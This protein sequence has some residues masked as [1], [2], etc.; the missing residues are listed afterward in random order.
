MTTDTIPQAAQAEERNRKPLTRHLPT[1]GRVL[2]GLV[3]L[4]T[5]LN[6]F[7]NFLPPPKTPMPPGAIAFAGAMLK[8]GYLF[9]LVAGTQLLVGALLL[10]NR[11]VPLALAL[12]APVVVN[13]FAFHAFLAPS[14]LGLAAVVAALEVYLAWAY[15]EAYRPM[16][17]LRTA[18][19]LTR[20]VRLSGSPEVE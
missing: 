20:S 5:G 1:I 4:V 9:H 15:R 16:L 19:S 18:P 13:I 2:M 10:A 17:A 14:G 11:F 12:I 3:F 7:L 6:G 8:T